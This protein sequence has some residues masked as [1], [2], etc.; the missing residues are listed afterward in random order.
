MAAVDLSSIYFYQPQL[1]VDH[2]VRASHPISARSGKRPAAASQREGKYAGETKMLD[3]GT[4][5]M[6]HQKMR[7]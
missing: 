1:E 6:Q 4:G 5:R 3:A 7:G 2:P